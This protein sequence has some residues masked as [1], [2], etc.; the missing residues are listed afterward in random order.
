MMSLRRHA[1]LHAMFAAALLLSLPHPVHAALPCG[2]QPDITPDDQ[3]TAVKQDAK[4][5]A[6]R[7]LTSQRKDELRGFVLTQRQEM[8]HDHADVD[9]SQLDAYL[10]WVTCQTISDDPA[11]SGSQKF[12]RYADVYRLLNE[13]I[14]G[15]VHTE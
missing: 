14:K 13:P 3:A 9:A 8:R 12:D 5:R 10:L 2:T 6:G 1:T 7:I 11:T 4:T 15:P